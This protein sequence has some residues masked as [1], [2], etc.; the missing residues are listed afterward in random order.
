MGK[1]CGERLPAGINALIS[2]E[3]GRRPKR[4]LRLGF[5]LLAVA[6]SLW[7]NLLSDGYLSQA[8]VLEREVQVNGVTV[9]LPVP[10]AE[11]K[12]RI[13]VPLRPVAEALGAEVAY[14]A[15]ARA[16]LVSYREQKLIIPLGEW[17]YY[18]NGQLKRL[19]WAA[20]V[21]QDR[22]LVPIDFF[23]QALGAR[24]YCDGRTGNVIIT[25]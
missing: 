22:L 24:C 23:S 16:A 25:T 18:R 20:V 4:F 7:G 19:T 10:A 11:E 14:E 13:L 3:G 2:N 6:V 15:A 12:G 8:A 17:S 1:L 21:V 5:L 9:A